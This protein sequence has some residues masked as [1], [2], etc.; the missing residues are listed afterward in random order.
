[1]KRISLFTLPLLLSLAAAAP[2]GGE[3]PLPGLSVTQQA[4]L[5]TEQRESPQSRTEASAASAAP[6]A[7]AT[8]GE[9][10]VGEDLARQGDPP[11]P[12]SLGMAA[13]RVLGATAV[14]GVLMTLTLLVLRR[15]FHRSPASSRIRRRSRG[16]L[17]WRSLWGSQSR[18]AAD[19]LEVLERS[20]V[21]AKESVCI[22]RAGAERFLIGVTSSRISLLGR[23]DGA[24]E[25]A[26]ETEEPSGADFARGLSG[27]AV[28]RPSP[29]DE[30]FRALLARSRER[31]TRL[32]ADHVRAG[33]AP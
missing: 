7:P 23:L 25:I 18:S 13:S 11:R 10:A 26:E 1:M 31:V 4:D 21:G 15:L 17:S 2:A 30:S 28:P 5:G 12:P 27:T 19:R 8:P 14:V 32:G 33:N 29:A 3:K 6:T 24:R 9:S 20:Y 16:R 22:V